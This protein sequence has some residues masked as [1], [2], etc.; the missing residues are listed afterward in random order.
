MID[1]KYK[2]IYDKFTCHY[3]NVHVNP[4]HEI[5]EEQL[6]NLYNDLVN[7]MDIFDE[8]SFNYFINYIIKRLSGTEDAHT[9]YNSVS[10]IPMNFKIFD[11]EVLIN[12][13]DHLR[14]SK[15][16]SINGISTEVIIDE[17]DEIITYGTKGKRKHQLERALFNEYMLLGLPSL[18]NVD[19]LIFKIEKINGEIITREFPKKKE[20]TK[21]EISIYNKYRYGDNATYRFIDNCLVYNHSSLQMGFKEKIENVV[22]NLRS[23]DLSNI[24][25]IIID[26]RGNTGGNAALNK[27]LI[28]FLKDNSDKL[29]ICLTDYRVFSGG[30]YALRDLIN[31]GAVTI[32]EEIATPINCYGNSNWVNIDGHEFSSSE[33]YFHPFLGWSATSK[34]EFNEEVTDELLKPVIFKPDIFI[35]EKKEDYIKGIDTVLNYATNYS[36]N[37]LPRM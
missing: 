33:A 25:T 5:S 26:I 36:K 27:I 24:D 21:E 10:L 20:N 11:N 29:L 17:L 23:E 6:N 15:L 9:L 2:N 16:I 19:K 35:E 7:S 31:L 3:K 30:R 13:P 37:K 22:A 18:K 8:Y 12:Y 4:W 34:N 28:D 1:I 32:G 14:G